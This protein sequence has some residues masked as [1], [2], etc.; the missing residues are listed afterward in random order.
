MI[1]NQLIVRTGVVCDLYV[2]FV[3]FFKSYI[4]LDVQIDAEADKQK[5]TFAALSIIVY[6]DCCNSSFTGTKSHTLDILFFGLK[7][8]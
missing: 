1:A 3:F 7:T 4:H 5:N 2:F 6:V 8:T